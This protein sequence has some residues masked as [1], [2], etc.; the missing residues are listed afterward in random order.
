MYVCVCMCKCVCVC[1]NLGV[2]V[3]LYVCECVFCM[4]VYYLCVLVL[5]NFNVY[6]AC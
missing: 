6:V 3:C 5:I 1:V 4:D 2:H